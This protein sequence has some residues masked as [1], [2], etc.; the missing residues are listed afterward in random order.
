MAIDK[1]QPRSW[2]KALEQGDLVAMA[3][4]RGCFTVMASLDTLST[5]ETSWAT[6]VKVIG[7]FKGRSA[8]QISQIRWT[9]QRKIKTG[10]LTQLTLLLHFSSTPDEESLLMEQEFRAK[11]AETI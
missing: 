11:H 4:L 7:N 8:H 5:L 2:W 9:I 3:V 1:P 10:T 6:F